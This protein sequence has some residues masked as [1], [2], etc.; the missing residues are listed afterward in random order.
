[1]NKQCIACK[2]K[3]N[4]DQF[5]NLVAVE[6]ERNHRVQARIVHEKVLNRVALCLCRECWKSLKPASLGLGYATIN[7]ELGHDKNIGW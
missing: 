3:L 5:P 7:T 6:L 4:R 1:M 2:R